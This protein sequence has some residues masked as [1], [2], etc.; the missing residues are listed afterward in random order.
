MTKY[1]TDYYQAKAEARKLGLKEA[2]Y[3]D[4]DTQVSYCGWNKSGDINDLCEIEAYYLFGK[5]GK[6]TTAEWLADW[7]KHNIGVEIGA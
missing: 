2:V 1:Y 3:G 7:V 6:P 5:N 4:W